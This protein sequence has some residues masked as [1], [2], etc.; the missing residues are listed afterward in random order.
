MTKTTKIL[1]S[2]KMPK[3]T[4]NANKSQKIPKFT[5]KPKITENTKNYQKCQKSPEM[6]EIAQ[7]AKIVENSENGQNA[8]SDQYQGLFKYLR[9]SHGLSAP[10]GMKDEVPRTEGPPTRSRGPEGP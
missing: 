5:E 6:S 9:G 2:P 10:K 3:I 8:E 7:T 1:T 4:E